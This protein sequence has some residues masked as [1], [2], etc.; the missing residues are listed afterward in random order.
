MREIA[1][2]AFVHCRGRAAIGTVGLVDG[3][4]GIVEEVLDGLAVPKSRPGSGFLQTLK[5]LGERGSRAR[6]E[7][8]A[9]GR[10]E[11]FELH[12]HA[13]GSA[14]KGQVTPKATCNRDTKQPT[15]IQ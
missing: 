6:R 14:S 11:E 10:A 9:A 2:R 8:A 13:S 12:G 4:E 1:Q 7:T 3:G 15:K 5:R